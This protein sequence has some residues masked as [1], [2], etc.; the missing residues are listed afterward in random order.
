[1]SPR[2]SAGFTL[3]ELMIVIAVIAILAT[4]AYPSYQSSVRKARRGDAIQYLLSMQQNE[5]KFRANNTA[6]CDPAAPLNGDCTAAKMGVPSG[7]G[8][9]SFYTFTITGVSATAYTATATIKAG[10]AQVGDTQAG[11]S[12][13]PLTINQSGVQSPA[14]CW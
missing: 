3:I 1:M 8:I 11:T 6:Y 14:G 2:K 5:E 7:Q 13:T 4:I 10:S 9:N 12:C